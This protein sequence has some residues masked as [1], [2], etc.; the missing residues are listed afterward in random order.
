MGHRWSHSSR[1]LF[2]PGLSDNDVTERPGVSPSEHP[3]PPSPGPFLLPGDTG[4]APSSSSSRNGAGVRL[5]WE[6]PPLSRGPLCPPSPCSWDMVPPPRV[7]VPSQ[8]AAP[9]PQ[10]PRGSSLSHR[11]PGT[12]PAGL[13]SLRGWWARGDARRPPMCL[14]A[15]TH[16]C[17]G[18]PGPP[19]SWFERHRIQF[20]FS[21]FA[22]Q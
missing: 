9:T 15:V 11:R 7:A 5:Y 19:E 18:R 12:R 22:L 1:T 10:A 13:P 14:S 4:L 20:S 16:H 8:G 6:C 17:W 2:G 21:N 3:A